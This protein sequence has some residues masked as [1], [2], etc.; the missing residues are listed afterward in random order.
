MPEMLSSGEVYEDVEGAGDP[1]AVAGEV[2]GPGFFDP[3]APGGVVA[4]P[5]EGGVVRVA[6]V[7]LEG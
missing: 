1:F 3:A 4:Q 7:E 5:D 2:A 6:L